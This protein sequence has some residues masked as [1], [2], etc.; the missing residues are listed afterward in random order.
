MGINVYNYYESKGWENTKPGWHKAKVTLK[1]EDHFTEIMDWLVN[2][3]SKYDRHTRWIILSESSNVTMMHFKFRY[4]KDY[5]MF[6]LRWS[7]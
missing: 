4:E 2:N 6:L 3:N 7:S 5:V 1:T